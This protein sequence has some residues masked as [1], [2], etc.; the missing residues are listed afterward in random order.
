MLS[1]LLLPR[2]VIHSHISPGRLL[3]S[4][5]ALRQSLRRG[6]GLLLSLLPSNASEASLRSQLQRLKLAEAHLEPGCALHLSDEAELDV[7]KTAIDGSDAVKVNVFCVLWCV[8]C[9]LFFLLCV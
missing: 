1:R 7:L 8:V 2:R 5:S 9:L 4:A 6:E 3:S